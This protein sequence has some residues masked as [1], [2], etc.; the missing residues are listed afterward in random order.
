MVWF[1]IGLAIIAFG[2]VGSMFPLWKSATLSPDSIRRRVY[3]TGCVVGVPLLFVGQLP[4][5]RSATFLAVGICLGVVVIAFNWTSHIK[6]GGRIYAA[7]TS[8]RAPDRPPALRAD[9]GSD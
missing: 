4:D 3:W 7:F 6:I 5:W 9:D 8:S 1:W 2:M